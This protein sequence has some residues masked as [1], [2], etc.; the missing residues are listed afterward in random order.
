MHANAL[1][2]SYRLLRWENRDQSGA[3]TYPLGADALGYISY[4]EDG[5]V[6][7]HIMAADRQPFSSNDLFGGTDD[8]IQAAA[9]SH[10]SYCGSYR[11]EANE[12]IHRVELCSYPNWIGSE[13]RRQYQFLDGNLL[14]SAQGIK[15]GSS[16]FEARLLW[17][18][19]SRSSA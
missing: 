13:Q 18:P 7:V 8:E 15:I 9:R 12:V 17:Q 3:V 10:I 6:F 1:I 2:G 11:L 19:L 16:L 4:A 14:L 5:H